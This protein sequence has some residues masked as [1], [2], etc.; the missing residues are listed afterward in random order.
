MIHAIC[1]G[2]FDPITL[3][4]L[5]VIERSARLFDKVIV[6]VLVNS[7]KQTLFTQEERV[8]MIRHSTAHLNNVEVVAFGGL[9]ADLAR[10]Y[11]PAVLVKGLR[12]T[13]DFEY[14][15]QMYTIQNK[16]LSQLDT[17]FLPCNQIYSHVSSTAAREMVLYG[18]DSS[19]YISGYVAEQLKKKF[20]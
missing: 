15:T 20:K 7:L 13:V 8:D 17:I 9:L 14:E 3:G 18:G 11:M 6:A 1:P 16:L 19:S 2:T 10:E 5:D 4:H 12:T